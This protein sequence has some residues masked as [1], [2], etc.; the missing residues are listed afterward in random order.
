MIG[1][2]ADTVLYSLSALYV[3]SVILTHIQHGYCLIIG[4]NIYLLV[5]I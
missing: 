4:Y 5:V 2:H 3:V 1:T